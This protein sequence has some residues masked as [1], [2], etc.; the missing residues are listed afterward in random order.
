MRK[1][2]LLLFLFCLSELVSA[3][4][5]ITL[6]NGEILN[7]KS[8]VESSGM[9]LVTSP[10]RFSK[11][12]KTTELNKSEVFSYVHQG[13]EVILYVQDSAFGDV[14]SVDE[15]RM[16]LAGERDARENYKANHIA[17]IGYVICGA[18]SLVVGDGLLVL[19]V[20]PVA[21]GTMQL[22]GKVKIRE[23]YISDKNYKFN[24]VYAEGFEPPARSKKIIKGIAGGV[25]GSVNGLIIYFLKNQ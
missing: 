12:M 20:P 24:D 25:L 18:A 14:Y 8:V 22:I 6:M 2:I 15:M 11:K 4:E 10:K 9:I 5:I 13:K 23:K 17:F 19:I 1:T 21:Y 16:Y 3:Q 7:V